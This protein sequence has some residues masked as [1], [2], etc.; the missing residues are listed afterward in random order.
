MVPLLHK[1][2]ANEHEIVRAAQWG[3]VMGCLLRASGE[4]LLKMVLLALL[5]PVMLVG[6]TSFVFAL[7]LL[8]PTRYLDN[9]RERYSKVLAA[10]FYVVTHGG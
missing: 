8:E 6:S 2:V 5:L 9:V 1:E 10:W 4:I 7:A 3:V